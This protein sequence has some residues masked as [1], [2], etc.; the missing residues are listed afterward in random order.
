MNA[1]KSAISTITGKDERPSGAARAPSSRYSQGIA[2][3]GG[4]PMGNVSTM[5]RGMNT[6]RLSRYTLYLRAFTL[7]VF[8]CS[9]IVSIV[10][11]VFQTKWIGGLSGLTGFL[12]FCN[13]IFILIVTFFTAVPLLAERS[14]GKGLADLERNLREN[15]VGFV[16]NGFCLVLGIIVA[17]TQTISALTSKGC[18]DPAQDPH[19]KSSK[20]KES[21]YKD[22]LSEFCTSKRAQAAFLWIGWF[23][24]IGLA[25]MFFFTFK[26]SRKAG[27]RIPP[28]V[29][30][31]TEGAFQALDGE[32]RDDEGLG[33]DDDDPYSNHRYKG[34]DDDDQYAARYA[35]D[36]GPQAP[37]SYD[38]HYQ[39]PVSNIEARYGMHT[40]NN[41][42]THNPFADALAQARPMSNAPNYQSRQSYDYGA[43][44]SQPPHQHYAPPNPYDAVQSHVSGAYR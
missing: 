40:N 41:A 27:P 3:G 18:K 8:F 43:Y 6:D 24:F 4:Q 33:H 31:E 37:G 16:G 10:I 29:A 21:D 38:A 5:G 32:D 28:F 22:A 44:S 36:A 11:A 7:L 30:G 35:D 9:L 2:G 34:Y 12:L 15:R 20:G 25:V 14:G 23:C 39:N 17:V 19:A 13:I 26:T 42:P 1:F